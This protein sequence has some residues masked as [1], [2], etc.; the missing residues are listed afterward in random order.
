MWL[1]SMGPVSPCFGLLAFA[2]LLGGRVAASL[3]FF[4]AAPPR[5]RCL[6][7]VDLRDAMFLLDKIFLGGKFWGADRKNRRAK[8]NNS[9]NQVRCTFSAST[10]AVADHLLPRSTWD[11][12]TLRPLVLLVALRFR[13]MTHWGS[14]TGHITCPITG[15]LS[16]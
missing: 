9:H 13:K 12:P 3:P 1:Q 8:Q 15:H 4:E 14:V 16:F 6:Y 7:L 10:K 2:A 11:S 5:R